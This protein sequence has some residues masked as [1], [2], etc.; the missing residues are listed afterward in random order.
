ALVAPANGATGVSTLS[1]VTLSWSAA[2]DST[3]YTIE[4][5]T[6]AGF[7]NIV[8]TQASQSGTSWN[9]SGLQSLTTY[10]WRVRAN[11]ICGTGANS[12]VFSFKTA[13]A[14]GSC[15][16]NQTAN[17]LFSDN[18]EGDVSGWTTSAGTGSQTWAVSTARPSSPTK[19]WLATDVTTASDQRLVSPAVVLPTGQSPLSL[20]FQSDL[21]LEPRTSGGCYDGGL[22]E[23]STNNGSTWTQ[24]TGAA[25]LTDP[26]TGAANGGAANGLQVW[27]GTRPYKNSVV[28][29]DSYAGQ[30]VRFR[31]R[32]STD[33]SQ[34]LTPHGWYVDDV[35]VQSCSSAP[36]DRIFAAGFEP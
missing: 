31:F 13:Q 4:V 35:K 30:T 33:S 16:E 25:L 21:N 34:G 19:A 3:S 28:D 32:V 18:V 20:S 10:Y 15:G 12:P 6:D 1:P 7:A 24:I 17:V 8:A 36:S 5:A 11:N 9:V 22:L 14:P 2:S 27:C 29:L 26:Y 23:I